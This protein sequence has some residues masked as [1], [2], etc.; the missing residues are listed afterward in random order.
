MAVPISR[1]GHGGSEQQR[2]L[3][4]DSQDREGNLG[5]SLPHSSQVPGL[6]ACL[7]S[8]RLLPAREPTGLWLLSG[9]SSVTA[10]PSTH[11]AGH[12]LSLP[13][14][15]APADL[16]LPGSETSGQP[17]ATPPWDV[18]FSF[19]LLLWAWGPFPGSRPQGRSVSNP[20]NTAGCPPTPPYFLGGF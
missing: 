5:L 14:S 17:S 4:T 18:T 11:H 19:T 7:F 9:L 12:L 13:P 3:N 20:E 15:P 6:P 2:N 16:R 8:L 1:G 10:V